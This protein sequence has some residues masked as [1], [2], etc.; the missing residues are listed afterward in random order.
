MPGSTRHA[1]VLSWLVV[2]LVGGLVLILV[3]G[4]QLFPRLNAGQQV[5]NGAAPAFAKNRVAA[6]PAGISMVTKVVDMADP[7]VEQSGGA[8]DDISN[9]VTFL[10]TQTGH[11]QA[12]LL[13]DLSNRFPQVTGLLE[14]VPLSAVTAEIPGLLAYVGTLLGLTPDQVATVLPIAFPHLAQAINALPSET[15]GWDNVPGVAGRLTNFDGTPV[16]TVPQLQSYLQ[17]QVVPVIPAQETN[18]QRLKGDWPPVHLI[19]VLLTIVGA[20]VI[21]FGLLMMARVW[22]GDPGRAE[23]TATW[24]VVGL[25]G[26]LVL[27]LVFGFALYPRLNGGNK[28]LTALDP[29]FQ[30]SRVQGTQAG[31][32]IISNSVDLL[33]PVVTAAGGAQGDISNLVTFLSTQTGQTPAQI[34]NDLSSQ[35][36]HATG[37][38]EAVPLTGVA[39]ELPNF[40]AYVGT[41][42]GLTPA[43]VE[44][45]LPISFPHLAQAVFYLPAVTSG[46]NNIPHVTGLTDF[47]G[48]PVHTVFQLRHYFISDVI[49]VLTS[50]ETNYTRLTTIS[51][52]VNWFPTLLTIVGI[53]AIVY[54]LAMIVVVRKVEPRPKPPEPSVATT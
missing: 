16:Q 37:L 19:P 15:A 31:G 1:G 36:P 5:L 28:L 14:A 33:D 44:T 7:I 18:F 53:L 42:L 43:Q 10:A 49:P 23:G 9:L 3:F 20:V 12:Q 54:A 38:L 26:V 48:A 8:A 40:I 29:V 50:Q 52:P 39:Q 2:V 24:G 21:F 35:F 30:Q 32:V 17:H 11:T 4:L 22:S 51:P 25:V 34:L 6:D 41:L 46:W 45:V 13:S 27:V 47:S